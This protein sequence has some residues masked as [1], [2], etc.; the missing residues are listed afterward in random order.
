MA[1]GWHHVTGPFDGWLGA[2]AELVV[3]LVCA[4]CGRHS[5]RWCAECEDE[6]AL[7][8]PEPFLLQE[9]PGTVTVAATELSGP[10]GR[11]IVA[12]KDGGRLDL[13]PLLGGAARSALRAALA[14]EEA[15]GGPLA[16]P[17]LV[18]PVPSSRRAVRRRGG[19]PLHAVA[20]RATAAPIE[21]GGG[22]A[23][24]SAL[25]WG[26]QV[27]DQRVL[28]RAQ[29]AANVHGAMVVPARWDALL[30][31]FGAVAVLDDVH[32]TGATV[33]EAARALRSTGV[34]RV[35]AAVVAA[36]L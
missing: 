30:G 31:S 36:A 6:A 20:E 15:R 25:R 5:T 3:P 1:A 7:A 29:R 18:V 24:A 27:S 8:R 33:G 28:G 16:G 12:W 19:R 14:I 17:V 13:V 35:C 4:G 26:R 11:A 34:R 10:V 23:W 21:G 2:A 32:T 22:P 9:G